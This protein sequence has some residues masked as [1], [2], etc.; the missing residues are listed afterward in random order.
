MQYLLPN[1]WY[2]LSCYAP[3]EMPLT[4]VCLTPTLRNSVSKFVINNRFFFPGLMADKLGSYDA[5]FYGTG[6]MVIVGACITFLLKFTAEPTPEKIN[7]E[8]CSKY[9]ELSV[10]EIVTVV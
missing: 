7:E 10:I 4:L 3:W 1:L 2:S 5:A 8:T 6:A 9:V